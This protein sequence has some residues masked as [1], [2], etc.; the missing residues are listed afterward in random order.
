MPTTSKRLLCRVQNTQIHTTTTHPVFVYTYVTNT[1]CSISADCNGIYVSLQCYGSCC[2]RFCENHQNNQKITS[3][4]IGQ[5]Y[6]TCTIEKSSIFGAI[7][8]EID[9]VIGIRLIV[10]F[11]YYQRKLLFSLILF[12]FV[13][14]I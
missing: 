3:S 1:D 10:I 7:A 5:I 9:T 14:R 13:H 4:H 2:N 12:K 6:S 11:G 8:K